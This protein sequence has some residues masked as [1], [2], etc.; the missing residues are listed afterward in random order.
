[1]ETSNRVADVKR[2][3]Q[4]LSRQYPNIEKVSEEIINLQAI[5]NLPKGTE[6]FLSDIHGEYCSFSHILNN[7]SGIIR[8][9]I[10]DSFCNQITEQERR[11]LATLIYYPEEKLALIKKDESNLDE[12]YGIILYRL[13]QVAREVSSKYTRSKV[14]KA[15]QKG[16]DYIIDEL[17]NIKGSANDKE[18]YYSQIIS[19]IIELGRADEFIVAI[20]DLIKR[21]AIDHLHVVGD[22]FDRGAEAKKVMNT[23]MNFH[24][25]DIQWGNHDVLWMGAASGSKECICNI[26]RIHC[27]YDNLDTIEDDYGINIRPLATFAL[28]AYRDDDCKKFAPKTF[29]YN[30][31][32]RSDEKTMA[33]MQKA[34]SIIQFKLEGQLVLRRPE[35][36]MDDRLLLDKINY[37][38]GT[39]KV[40]GQTYELNDTHFPTID[41]NDPYKLTEEEAEIIDRL[42]E[43]FMNSETLQRHISFLYSKGSIYKCFNSNLLFHA[44][45]PMDQDGEFTKVT[46]LGQT[47][48]G[49]AYLDF[50]DAIIRRAYF[51][52]QNI[53]EN[54]EYLDL[55]WYFWCGEQ[56]PAFGKSKM[57]TLERYFTSDKALHK[58]PKNPYF[59]LIE[60]EE[61]CDKVLKEFGLEGKNSYIINGHIPVKEKNGE[62]PIRAKGKL[63]V[64]DGGL[65]K[66]Y[67][68]ETGRAG[69][70]LTYNSYGLVLSA[71]EPF[72]SKEEAIREEKDIKYE[73]MVNATQTERK[74]VADT[75]IG[76]ELLQQIEDLKLLLIAYRDGTLQEEIS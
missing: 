73:I 36:N 52:R 65:S 35:Y 40:D 56:S 27:R 66:S 34:I 26:I 64:I 60:T 4:I 20:S 18:H 7:G 25:V 30:K 32:M 37:K 57:A 3:L 44:C 1:M 12:W 59:K 29:D 63:L 58:E 33:K 55:M 31:Y 11:Q 70:T 75:D 68:S 62:S 50:V 14:R 72:D 42:Q 17:L 13:I 15:L 39:L 6:L 71:S 28:E 47:L 22:I 43:S 21:M 8:K 69:Y 10:E 23:L 51:N 45:I 76:Q 49:K 9:K 61:V 41:P 48:S 2:Y 38:K 24:S 74:R 54:Q 19:S 46:M 5:S 53:E 16:F 67:R